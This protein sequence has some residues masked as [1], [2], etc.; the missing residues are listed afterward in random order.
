MFDTTVEGADSAIAQA[1][2]AIAQ[3]DAAHS[4]VGSVQRELLAAI[5]EIDR[6][7]S[8]EDGP[9]RDCA[10]WVSMRYG[11]SHWK[12]SRWL[13][14]GR[15]LEQLPLISRA[16]C[17]GELSIDQVVELCRFA[18]PEWESKL[19]GWART[20]S[21]GALR[22][23][24]DWE[25]R[26]SVKDAR[27]ADRDRTLSWWW[28]DEGRRLGLQGELPAADG[29]RVV[30]ALDRLAR[31]L[32]VMPGEE[33]PVYVDQRRADALV[34]MC[35]AQI[36]ADPDP[37]RATVI[38]HATLEGLRTNDRG[39]ELE[40]GPALHPETVRRLLCTSRVQTIVEDERGEVVSVGRVG[41]EPSSWLRRQVRYRDRE[42]RFPG[43]GARRFT[44][45]HH[46]KWWRHGGKTT[47]D[48][49]ILIC[50]FHHKLVHGHGWRVKRRTDGDVHWFRPDGVRYRAGPASSV[51]SSAAIAS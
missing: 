34:A 11:I 44:E 17:N 13:H 28:T 3:A 46:I 45:P 20:V 23:R 1:D 10:H 39:A 9:A 51:S 25:M 12:A 35:S 47:L 26:M 14:A 2:S 31:E 22:R 7:S 30:K 32:P 27:E 15:A 19:I 33:D 40:D 41:R 49:L 38:V 42:C 5:A 18:T 4:R 21:V 6:S 24:G 48:N 37:D 8:W 50:S 29:A 36:G 16:L 43:C